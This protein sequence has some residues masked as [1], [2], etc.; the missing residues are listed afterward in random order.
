MHSRDWNWP[1]VWA[2]RTWRVVSF[3]CLGACGASV[4]TMLRQSV[5]S[6]MD[7]VWLVHL[8][9][10]S[11]SAIFSM[12]LERSCIS[13]ETQSSLAYVIPKPSLWRGKQDHRNWSVV[14]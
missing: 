11:A 10:W 1:D 9:T 4:E 12:G 7:Y 13:R 2:N 5:C 6:K 3:T 14:S 8:I